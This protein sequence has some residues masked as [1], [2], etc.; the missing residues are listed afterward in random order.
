MGDVCVEVSFFDKNNKRIDFY[1]YQDYAER[2]EK[3]SIHKGV[4]Y[5]TIKAYSSKDDIEC[6]SSEEE[7]V[8]M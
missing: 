3:I 1:W 5:F 4:R 2:T 7:E 6:T 8:G